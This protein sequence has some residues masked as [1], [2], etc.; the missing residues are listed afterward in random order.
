MKITSLGLSPPEKDGA[1]VSKTSKAL[2]PIHEPTKGKSNY[3]YTVF[4]T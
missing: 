2:S 1:Y 4:H 3:F